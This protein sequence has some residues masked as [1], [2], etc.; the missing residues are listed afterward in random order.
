M[1]DSRPMR[2]HDWQ[3]PTDW[4]DLLENERA[5]I[6]ALTSDP[7]PNSTAL[8]HQ[9]EH[10]KAQLG[11]GCGCGTISLAVNRDLADRA[12]ASQ[13]RVHSEALVVDDHDN[14]IGGLLL[15]IDD[16]Y[17]DSLEVYTFT[18]D[19]QPLPALDSIRLPDK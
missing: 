16:G 11:C 1:P 14:F 19:P 6:D 8:R 18:D 13:N 9:I 12:A 15:F 3:P 4:R 5:L 10:A 2:S 7:F 17:I